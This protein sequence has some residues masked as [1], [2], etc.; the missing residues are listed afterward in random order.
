MKCPA[1]SRFAGIASQTLTHL[2]AKS[3]KTPFIVNA[4]S[5]AQ[6]IVLG[7]VKVDDN[8]NEITAMPLLEKVLEANK[9]PFRKSKT[10]VEKHHGR[11]EKRTCYQTDYIGWFQ[12]K[13]GWVGLRSVIMVVSE[14]TARASPFPS[15]CKFAHLHI[16]TLGEEAFRPL[17]IRQPKTVLRGKIASPTFKEEKT[18]G[19]PEFSLFSVSFASAF[20]LHQ[21]WASSIVLPSI[22]GGG[23]GGRRRPSCER[24]S[25]TS[26]LGSP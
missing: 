3:G 6:G 16:C 2:A 10:V 9:G 1:F 11:I 23:C 15:V 19:L 22:F 24:T 20:P 21:S 26:F 14:R 4:W 25:A 17:N 8:S 12:D 5:D 7:E 18:P 13:D